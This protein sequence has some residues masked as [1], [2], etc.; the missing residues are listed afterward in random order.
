MNSSK[1]LAFFVVLFSLSLIGNFFLFSIWHKGT[2]AVQVNFAEKNYPFLSRRAATGTIH[3]DILTNFVPLRKQLR[4]LV[5]SYNDEFAF[6]FEYLPTGTSIGIHE[7]DE[8]TAASLLKVPVVMAYY[9]KKETENI[10]QDPVV[11]IMP[12]ELDEHF[13]DLYKKGAGAQ[14]SL[15]EAAKIALQQSD[16]TASFILADNISND[17]FKFVYEGLDIEFTVL[18]DSPVITAQQYTSILKSLYFSSILNRDDSQEILDLLTN[19]RFKDMLP[20]PIPDDIP[21]AHKIGL[22]NKQIYQDCGI[23]Y[24]PKRP[25]TLCMISKSDRPTAEQRMQAVSKVVYEY[26]A[27]YQGVK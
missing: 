26:V 22:I 13:G 15:G 27:A 21:V 2:D 10:T 23:V 4:E 24:L 8:F 5:G 11:T 17:D 7:D 25:Y 19:T 3:N 12:K 14:I 9:H 1:A 16:N 18:E 6:Y 20:G